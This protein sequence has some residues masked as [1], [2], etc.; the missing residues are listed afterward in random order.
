MGKA[1]QKL[2]RHLFAASHVVTMSVAYKV[3]NNFYKTLKSFP[4]IF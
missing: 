4:L 3:P 2:M 1:G